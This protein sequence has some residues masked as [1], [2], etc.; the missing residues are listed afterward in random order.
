LSASAGLTPAL[1]ADGSI[2]FRDSKD[3]GAFIL[4]PPVMSDSAPD[5]PAVS[6]AIHYELGEEE[7]GGHWRLPVRPDDEWL[8]APERIWPVRIDPTI[9]IGPCLDCV[10]GGKTG[11]TGWIDCASWGR[12]NLLAGYTPQLESKEDSWWRALL[13][14][15]TSAIPP[16]ATVNSAT[17]H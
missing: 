12:N 10:I 16:T 2:V 5:H 4:P 8:S 3:Q 6:R 15:E 13:D 7:Q 1:E 14:L 17:F 11:Q 9:S